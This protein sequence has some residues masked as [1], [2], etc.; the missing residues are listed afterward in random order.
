MVAGSSTLGAMVIDSAIQALLGGVDFHA[1]IVS[2]T[3]RA[4]T[5][6]N[7]RQWATLP[8]ASYFQFYQTEK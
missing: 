3:P 1:A 6:A 2:R 8:G 4:V 7:R 5:Y